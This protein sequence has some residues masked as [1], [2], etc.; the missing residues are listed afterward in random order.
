M[1]CGPV[2]GSPVG[3]S[4]KFVPICSL[5]N[6]EAGTVVDLV[7][8]VREVGDLIQ[9]RSK[10][11]KD[12]KKCEIVLADNSAGG[13]S[14]NLVLWAKQAVE[15]SCHARMLL[16]LSKGAKLVEYNGTKYIS[17]GFGH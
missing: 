7:A 6:T 16:L 11:E 10:A 12:L 4:Y 17:L 9:F 14:V 3:Q 5:E 15:F 2:T 8:W 13:S 1:A